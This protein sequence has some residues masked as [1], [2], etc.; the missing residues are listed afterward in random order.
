MKNLYE[1]LE[2][3]YGHLR[4][5]LCIFMTAEINSHLKMYI[6]RSKVINTTILCTDQRLSM[7]GGGGGGGGGACACTQPLS[8]AP[9]FKIMIVEGL[10]YENFI[11]T[12]SVVCPRKRT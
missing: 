3:K 6:C 4:I 11:E 7:G 12:H 9:F 10:V 2:K 5:E 8:Q 1:D